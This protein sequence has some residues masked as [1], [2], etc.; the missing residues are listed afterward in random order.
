MI[1]ALC[2]VGGIVSLLLGEW[3]VAIACLMIIPVSREIL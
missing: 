3:L 2:I 1:L